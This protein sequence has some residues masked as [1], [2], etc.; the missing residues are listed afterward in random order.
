[1]RTKKC[2]AQPIKRIFLPEMEAEWQSLLE[3]RS[4]RG[5]A[6]NH[7]KLAS[8]G[9]CHSAQKRWVG[10]LYSN[11]LAGHEKVGG[12]SCPVVRLNLLN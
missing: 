2:Y 11:T 4:F 8:S 6:S 7:F 3:R 9:D 12:L 5:R 1:M 10:R